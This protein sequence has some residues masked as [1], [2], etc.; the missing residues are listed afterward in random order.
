[1]NVCVDICIYLL[2]CYR[3]RFVSLCIALPFPHKYAVS[4]DIFVVV[5]DDN[6]E[7]DVDIN[8]DSNGDAYMCKC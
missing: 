8:D 1:M 6:V 2:R 7:K 3:V 4:D 5:D